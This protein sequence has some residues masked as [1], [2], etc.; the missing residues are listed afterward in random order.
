MGKNIFS[1]IIQNITGQLE[2]LKLKI[3]AKVDA[4]QKTATDALTLAQ[5]N[6]KKIDEL[7]T[8]T[9]KRFDEV[10]A[11]NKSLKC[12]NDNLEKRIK[13]NIEQSNNS[14]NYS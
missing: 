8:E 13:Q 3:V 10:I 1:G 6:Q 12:I 4:V 2:A 14:E 5:D 7:T 11:E 9:N